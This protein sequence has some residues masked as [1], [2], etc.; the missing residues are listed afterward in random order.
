[1]NTV[2]QDV[3][4]F[5]K[6]FYIFVNIHVTEK[7]IGY[8]RQFHNIEKT[9]QDAKDLILKRGLSLQVEYNR[10][11][12]TITVSVIPELERMDQAWQQIGDKLENLKSQLNN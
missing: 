9:V 8:Q 2:H 11:L 1:M 7:T 10:G 4:T 12:G 6:E 5:Q 3:K